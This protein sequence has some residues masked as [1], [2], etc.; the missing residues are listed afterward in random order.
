MESLGHG[1]IRFG[2]LGDLREHVAFPVRLARARAAARGRLQLLS[3]LAHRGSFLVR[4]SLGCLAGGSLP[5]LL[6]GLLWAHRTSLT[7]VGNVAA[8]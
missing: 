6:R 2:H 7:W 4:E 1:A 5:G 8:V 3:A